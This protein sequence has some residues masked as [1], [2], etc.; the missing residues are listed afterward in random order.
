M[1]EFTICSAFGQNIERIYSHNIFCV[2]IKTDEKLI[3]QVLQYILKS[4]L[5]IFLFMLNFILFF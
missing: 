5:A 4:Q 3:L 1:I 2:E